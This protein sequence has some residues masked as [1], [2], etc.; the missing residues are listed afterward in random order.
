MAP[1]AETCSSIIKEGSKDDALGLRIADRSLGRL[2]NAAADGENGQG[3]RLEY[4]RGS[5][6]GYTVVNKDGQTLYCRHPGAASAF[7]RH[8]IREKCSRDAL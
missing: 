1:C 8:A 4:R 6:A 2:R 3:R 7:A 5:K